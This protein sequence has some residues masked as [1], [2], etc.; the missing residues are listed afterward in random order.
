MARLLIAWSRPRHVDALSWA[1]QQLAP[2]RGLPEVR[3]ISLA[4]VYPASQHSRSCE[5]LCEL[6]LHEGADAGTCVDRPECSDW[7]RDMHLLGL[8][9]RVALI[10]DDEVVG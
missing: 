10:D 9:P 2:L 8:R 6:F 1:R 5:W 7:I 3:S 4:R